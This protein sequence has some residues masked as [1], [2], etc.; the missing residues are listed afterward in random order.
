MLP[1]A[2]VYV[3][4][5]VFAL[6][7]VAQQ[8]APSELF[9]SKTLNATAADLFAQARAAKT[10]IAYKILTVHPDGNEQLTVRVKSGQGEWHH[11]YADILIM[12]EGEAQMVTGGTVVN[13]TEK[14]GEIR[15]DSVTGGKVQPFHAGEMIRIEPQVAHQMLLSPG[16]SVKY[17]TVKIKQ[18]K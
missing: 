13:G 15:G 16:A 8:T 3:L 6:P 12:L 14:D 17:F 18:S 11:D 2:L 9:D 7:S 10:G 1:K 5:I 4:P